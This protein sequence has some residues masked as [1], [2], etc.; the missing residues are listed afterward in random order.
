MFHGSIEANQAIDVVRAMIASNQ[1]HPPALVEPAVE[2]FDVPAL[3]LGQR[4]ER[5]L[6]ERVIAGFERS[7]GHRGG[8]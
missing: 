2:R 4:S 3:D 6:R 8:F 7:D 5:P 1:R